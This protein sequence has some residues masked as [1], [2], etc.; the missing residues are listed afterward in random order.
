MLAATACATFMLCACSGSNTINSDTRD[1]RLLGLWLVSSVETSNPD[2]GPL[3]CQPDGASIELGGGESVSCG[4]SDTYNFESNGNLTLSDGTNV[5][6][7][8]WSTGGTNT[9]QVT[10]NGETSTG[11]YSV[12]G[13]NLE[14]SFVA[15]N[16][17]TVGTLMLE[18]VLD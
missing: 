2:G 8:T 11:S 12:S 4:S 9:I 17:H 3:D 15:P 10:A 6:T 16:G 18:R 14:I 13:N 7:G 1:P 5:D